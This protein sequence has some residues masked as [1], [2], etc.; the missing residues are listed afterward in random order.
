FADLAVGLAR[1]RARGIRRLQHEGIQRPRVLDR[2]QMGVG[3]FERRKSFAR[4]T[5][6]GLGERKRSQIGHLLIGLQKKGESVLSS[7]ASSAKNLFVFAFFS[8]LA[9]TSALT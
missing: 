3:E 7:V 5:L 9:F 2:L 6:T 8:A 4:K 1:H